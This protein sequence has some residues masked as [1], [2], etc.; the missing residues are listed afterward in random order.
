M[1]DAR[2]CDE[3]ETEK[4]IF[5][6][7]RDNEETKY[8]MQALQIALKIH[9]IEFDEY[10]RVIQIWLQEVYEEYN[11]EEWCTLDAPLE[12]LDSFDTEL[13]W[14]QQ[15]L[16]SN[17]GCKLGLKHLPPADALRQFILHSSDETYDMFEEIIEKSKKHIGEYEV[18]EYEVAED[19]VAH[20]DGDTRRKL[21]DSPHVWTR[22][23]TELILLCPVN[24][25]VEL[26][27]YLCGEIMRD[28]AAIRHWEEQK[29]DM[30]RRRKNDVE[31]SMKFCFQNGAPNVV[32]L[33]KDVPVWCL[34]NH[35]S[36]N[37]DSK[38]KSMLNELRTARLKSGL[39]PNIENLEALLAN[40]PDPLQILYPK[41]FFYADRNLAPDHTDFDLFGKNVNG[42]DKIHGLM[43]QLP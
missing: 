8:V 27:E 9:S 7:S 11:E 39:E 43:Q 40:F 25:R 24:K 41:I 42:A 30:V 6:K 15:K 2:E 34:I 38:H 35:V 1:G 5:W 18:A 17:R 19:Q 29:D 4:L 13:D 31:F 12:M 28:V 33:L 10:H 37:L 26:Y 16:N 14:Y 22:Q 32:T 3:M 36:I 21:K 23:V 20:F